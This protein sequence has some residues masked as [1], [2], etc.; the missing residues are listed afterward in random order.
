M[1]RA[2]RTLVNV[3]SLLLSISTW[4][5]LSAPQ[6]YAAL[7]AEQ[8]VILV[9]DRDPD[10]VRLGRFY[11][12]QRGIPLAHLIA[13]D[14]PYQES[15]SRKAYV[16]DLV[17][18]LRTALADKNLT[19]QIRAV[20]TMF[21]VPLKI[22][23]PPATAQEERWK[24]DAR[25]WQQATMRLVQTLKAKILSLL[26]PPNTQNPSHNPPRQEVSDANNWE[27]N[28]LIQST[29][30]TMTAA[31]KQLAH[32]TDSPALR[33]KK[34]TFGNIARQLL[35]LRANAF[36]LA[37]PPFFQAQPDIR[38]SR[39]ENLRRATTLLTLLSQ[40][41]S[42]KNR[43][44][45]YELAQ[46]YLGLL[47]VLSLTVDEF[48]KFSL[49][50]ADASV[51]SELSL[52]WYESGEYA[53]SERTPNPLFAWN[54]ANPSEGPEA[55]DSEFPLLMV[56]R[57][58]APTPLLAR[59]MVEYAVLAEQSGITG[60]AYIDARGLHF[61]KELGYGDYDESL[62]TLA[63]LLKKHSAYPVMLDNS[64]RRFSQPGEAPSV[65]IYAGW[66]RY[67]H[68]EDAFTFNPGAIGYHIASGEA[69]S[70]HKADERGWCKNA[71]ERGITATLGPTKEPYL[72]AFPKP[73]DFFG[74][75]FTGQY[76]L[77]EA[78]YLT[79]R[80]VSWRM[81]LFGDPLYNPWRGNPLVSFADLRKE[82]SS[83]SRFSQLPQPPS[84][85]KIPDPA[86][87]MH[88]RKQQRD[89]LLQHFPGAL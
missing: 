44:L 45:A 31:Q 51:D 55:T 32:Q 36:S 12:Q 56:S 42:D 29:I 78:Y 57:I 50:N 54:S 48:N 63:R 33:E 18:P 53:L 16:E 68:Y 46:R 65:G 35:G 6:S 67:R 76:S 72:D 60:N 30:S 34:E 69:I 25:E 61:D 19:G 15:I 49:M 70:I 89:K 71:L 87:A 1:A 58:D 37:N 39:S 80:Y 62:R 43:N 75:L 59:Q 7:T 41:P 28:Q 47:G 81:T 9:N 17:E 23:S 82:F 88:Q 21:G 79:I 38:S 84:A 85:R 24:N 26:E 11:A 66:Y 8:L 13:L 40:A 2:T 73:S 3:L 27:V 10:S 64:D 5:P 22:N 20:A 52:L 86:Q 14:L 74:L 77:V 83:F 4:G